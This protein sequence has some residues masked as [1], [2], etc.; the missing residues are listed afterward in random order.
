MRS[1]PVEKMEAIF[2]IPPLSKRRDCKLMVQATK[3]SAMPH[4]PYEEKN[5]RVL[6][7]QAEENQLRQAEQGTPS[8]AP[9]KP[10]Q[11]NSGHQSCWKCTTM[12]SNDSLRWHQNYSA[13]SHPWRSLQWWLQESLDS[14]H[15]RWT[16]SRVIMDPPWIHHAKIRFRRVVKAAQA[17]NKNT[18][19][20]RKSK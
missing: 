6:Q 10:A 15:D 12:G 7:Q 19:C 16:I 13:V 2:G 20:S 5:G 8:T 11:W 1:I 17:K 4:T 14:I 9:G 3:F 18:K